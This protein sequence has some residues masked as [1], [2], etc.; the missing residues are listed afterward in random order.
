MPTPTWS[1]ASS[2]TQAFASQQNQFLGTH[3]C[4]F[5]YQGINQVANGILTGSFAY[6]Y[7]ASGTP[8]TSINTNTGAAAQWIDQPFTTVAS[9]TT[10]TRV[11]L[12]PFQTGTSADTTVGL[13]ADSAGNPT[14]SALASTTLPA[15]FVTPMYTSS[16]NTTYTATS[17]TD[18]SGNFPYYGGGSGSA[19]TAVAL[20]FA[21]IL[22]T[23]ASFALVTATGTTPTAAM[24]TTT[25]TN[26]TTGVAA[27]P[28][29]TTVFKAYPLVSVPLNATGLS[30]STKYHIV[31]GGTASTAN[32]NNFVDTASVAGQIAQTGTSAT[33]PWTATT[34]TLY[35]AVFANA[36]GTLNGT[37]LRHTVEDAGARWTGIDYV[38][39]NA[40]HSAPN[41][42]IV[43]EYTTGTLR[44]KRLAVYANNANVV[45]GSGLL[46]SIS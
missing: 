46:Q 22:V 34:K 8:S 4:V 23:P 10:I 16:A 15:D 42:L 31:I 19:L 18:T 30:A 17:V 45:T 3:S 14:G 36:P 28:A 26:F 24:T 5:I 29:A 11:V 9:Q 37:A 21:W 27:T 39:V 6:E 13:F 25:W 44:S 1:A 38:L 12:F 20:I 41:P 33:G 7:A 43:S 40:V 32:Y 35:F 2:S